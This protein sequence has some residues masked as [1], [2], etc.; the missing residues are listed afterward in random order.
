MQLD[1]GRMRMNPYLRKPWKTK[2][3]RRQ[4]ATFS[5]CL[6][7]G[8]GFS[9][10]LIQVILLEVIHAALCGGSLA[11][12]LFLMANCCVYFKMSRVQALNETIADVS[13]NYVREM[14]QFIKEDQK[15]LASSAQ[16]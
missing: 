14:E 15:N 8:G 13:Q 1:E 3:R 5:L 9:Y 12:L 10:F 6:I 7:V 4:T 11:L 16:G 2:S